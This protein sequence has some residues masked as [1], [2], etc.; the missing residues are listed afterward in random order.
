MVGVHRPGPAKRLP[1]RTKSSSGGRP[2]R[3]SRGAIQSLRAMRS[4][5]ATRAAARDPGDR[6]YSVRPV[7]TAG[8]PFRAWRSYSGAGLRTRAFLAARLAVLPRPRR[9][10]RASASGSRTF[11]GLPRLGLRRGLGYR[12]DAPHRARRSGDARRGARAQRQARR[13]AADQGRRTHPW[14]EARRQSPSR[15][16]CGRRGHDRRRP[17]RSGTPVRHCRASTSSGSTGRRR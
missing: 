13:H 6:A 11:A 3:C 1:L 15:L 10:R 14:L 2:A 9:A 5:R 17:V 8:A 16:A 4:L 7:D 12:P